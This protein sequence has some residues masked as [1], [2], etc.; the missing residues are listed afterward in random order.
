MQARVR[1][2]FKENALSDEDA[3]LFTIAA[4]QIAMPNPPNANG[5][6]DGNAGFTPHPHL[7]GFDYGLLAPD[8]SINRAPL[9]DV[10]LFGHWRYAARKMKHSKYF[11]WAALFYL[12][13]CIAMIKYIVPTVYSYL[14]VFLALFIAA[15]GIIFWLELD[16]QT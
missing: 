9:A 15:F 2:Y 10:G 6:E 5:G 4:N 13:F 8:G 11:R 12:V 3:I 7:P 16:D 14:A 1:A